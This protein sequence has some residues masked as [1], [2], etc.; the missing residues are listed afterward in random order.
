MIT[1]GGIMLASSGLHPLVPLSLGHFFTVTD[2]TVGVLN[3]NGQWKHI[4]PAGGPYLN[5]RKMLGTYVHEF[6][7]R[8]DE[9]S[10][11]PY[12]ATVSEGT[13]WEVTIKVFN[14]VHGEDAVPVLN[15]L[16]KDYD[17][18]FGRILPSVVKEVM[19]SATNLQLRREASD[20]NELIEVKLIEQMDR[21]WGADIASKIHIVITTDN[22]R[23]KDMSLIARWNDIVAEETR[24]QH[25][26]KKQE[27]EEAEHKRH[28][29]EVNARNERTRAEEQNK[30]EVE[31][32]QNARAIT[33]A[34]AEAE[35]EGI[36]AAQILD[37]KAQEARMIEEY[38]VAAQHRAA[39]ASYSAFHDAKG[40]S[41]IYMT[42][43]SEGVM[44]SG[45]AGFFDGLVSNQINQ[46]QP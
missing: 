2:G 36:R 23:C 12:V 24:L 45:I 22:L 11:G 15:A 20:L 7:T 21:N 6:S 42:G 18:Q 9:D 34:E 43:G 46:E 27:T 25:L 13:P 26:I 3:S 38:P 17:M 1:L 16:G 44:N 10:F 41:R 14:Q 39:L 4:V 19:S 8:Q 30:L 40:T 28:L 32:I 5:A 29:A 31:R 35:A 33:K 37:A